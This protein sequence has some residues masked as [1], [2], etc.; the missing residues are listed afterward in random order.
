MQ[1][2][3]IVIVAIDDELL[4]NTMAELKA[5]FPD[6]EVCVCVCVCLCVCVCVSV[7]AVFP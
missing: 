6:Q 5:Q 4:K 3:N 1:K 2:L 7:C